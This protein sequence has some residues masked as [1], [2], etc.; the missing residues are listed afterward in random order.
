MDAAVK[1]KNLTVVLGGYFKALDAVDLELPE[2]RL[3]GFIGP[4][5]AGKTTLARAIVGRQKVAGGS[6][7]VFG[8]PAGSAG[9]RPRVGYMTQ[10][11]SVYGDLTVR[12][13]ITYFATMFGIR[14]TDVERRVTEILDIIDMRPQS[15]RLVSRLSG[16]QQRRVSLAIALI[17]KPELMVLDEPTVG[18]DPV[19]REQIWE[20]FHH[21]TKQGTTLIITSHVMDE[22]ERCDD[23]VLI[24]DGRI[25]AHEPPKALCAK[26]GSDTVE[27]SFLKL[28]EN[29]Q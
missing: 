27:Q 21:L 18:L 13:N 20:L 11:V 22:A 12:Q 7:S 6:V 25:L 23:L 29:K 28:V 10:S 15:G 17:G 19:L 2:G 24:R 9:L 4:S 1:I 14:R 8:Q 16:G 5:G 3:I 26:T